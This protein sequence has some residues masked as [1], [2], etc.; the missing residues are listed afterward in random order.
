MGLPLQDTYTLDWDA[1]IDERSATYK[2]LIP[3]YNR[4]RELAAEFLTRNNYDGNADAIADFPRDE[5]GQRQLVGEIY[6]AIHNFEAT[7]DA[8]RVKKS[9]N[10]RRL[11]NDD[12]DGESSERELVANHQVTRTKELSAIETELLAWDILV[13]SW[14]LFL[15]PVSPFCED[16]DH[17]DYRD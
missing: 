14:P 5:A 13:S 3:N 11:P 15:C 9:A 8:P 10:K 7:M 17:K 6:A 12:D 16:L 2:G 1:A 4:S